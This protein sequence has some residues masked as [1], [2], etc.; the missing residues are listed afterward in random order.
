LARNLPFL[1]RN[2][3]RAHLYSG[4]IIRSGVLPAPRHPC[5]FMHMPKCGGTSISEAMYATVPLG[6]GVAVI[7]A[8][9][10]RRAAAIL[11]FGR[12]DPL[13]CHEDQPHG[14]KVFDFRERLMLQQMAWGAWLVH[15][16]V[17]FSELADTHFGARYRYV[18]LLRDPV[19]RMI[20][21]YRMAVNAGVVPD[22]LDTYLDTPVAR[23]HAQ[24]YLRYL[25]GQ[26]IVPDADMSEMLA[27]AQSR[28][29]RFAVVG[30]LDDLPAFQRRYL[31]VFGVPLR[32]RTY[33]QGR[34]DKPRLSAGQMD[35]IAVLTAADQ[36]IYDSAKN[37]PFDG[38]AA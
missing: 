15:G 7:D 19:D 38:S 30:F 12:D 32:I 3:R 1:E 10:T 37:H 8:V 4:R 22:G 26:T 6:R 35:K 31:S 33:N 24:V 18:T 13:L 29:A 9:S 14:D 17:L 23:S 34:G 36:A 20:S 2:I 5:L 25:S 27:L 16:H 28:L 21:N 11:A